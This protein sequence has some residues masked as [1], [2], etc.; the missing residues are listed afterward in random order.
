MSN[1]E[2]RTWVET[3]TADNRIYYYDSITK[4]T[5]WTRPANATIIKYEQ[6]AMLKTLPVVVTG[7][8]VVDQTRNAV[9]AAL[10]MISE[11]DIQRRI[12]LTQISV[13]LRDKA[14]DWQEYKTLDLKLYYYNTKTQEKRWSKPD[15]V[16]QLDGKFY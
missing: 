14:V 12:Y 11:Q 1:Q 8:Q 9:P 5:T 2:L 10:P 15:V 7:P 16:Q 6:M 13:E 3:K 4:E